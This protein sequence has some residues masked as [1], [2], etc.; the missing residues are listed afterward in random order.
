MLNKP[1][2]FK[3][4]LDAL[5]GSDIIPASEFDAEAFELDSLDIAKRAFWSAN[6]ESFRFLQRARDFLTD[7][8]GEITEEVENSQGKHIALKGGGRA[9]FVRVMREFMIEEG[10]AEN[11]EEFQEVNQQDIRDIR[12]ERRLKLI[13]ETNMQQAYGYGQYKQGQHPAVLTRF[14]A[15]RFVRDR[16][17]E[18]PRPRHLESEGEVRLKSD[19][20]YWADFQN[21][22]E[23]GGFGVPW[24]PF[25]FYSG[26]GLQ[27]VDREEAAILGLDLEAPAPPA[28][29][30]KGLNDK[31]NTAVSNLDDDVKKRLIEELRGFKAKDARK[32]GA[33][34]ALRVRQAKDKLI[35]E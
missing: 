8:L 10:L 17:V 18:E 34:A 22:P 29:P 24:A 26:M 35:L 28:P 27:D 7:T 12:S 33:D 13:Y 1:T 4:A 23:I 2:I 5:L 21:D 15:Q 25:G 31:F 11:E 14:P 6:V 16:G 20:A 3:E 19:V 30:V 9:R 32:A